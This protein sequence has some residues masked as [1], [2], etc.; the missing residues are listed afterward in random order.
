MYVAAR[1]SGGR[2]WPGWRKS[3]RWVK[4]GEAGKV[5]LHWVCESVAV[6]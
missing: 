5:K 1:V 3:A 6:G 2:I 4:E